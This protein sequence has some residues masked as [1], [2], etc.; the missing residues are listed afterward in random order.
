MESS[1]TFMNNV[2]QTTLDS[3]QNVLQKKWNEMQCLA[4]RIRLSPGNRGLRV[5]IS[6]MMQPTDHMSTERDHNIGQ[7]API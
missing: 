6:P 7:S 1:R 4:K 2:L 3:A 5:N